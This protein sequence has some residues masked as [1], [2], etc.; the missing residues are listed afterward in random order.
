VSKNAGIAVKISGKEAEGKVQLRDELVRNLHC[1]DEVRKGDGKRSR[2]GREGRSEEKSS[3]REAIDSEMSGHLC[4]ETLASR[5][6]RG[7]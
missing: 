6:G 7:G 5:P 3:L 1:R 4:L 2:K